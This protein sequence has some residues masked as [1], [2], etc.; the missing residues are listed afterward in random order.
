M[1]MVSS[2]VF[3]L[4]EVVYRGPHVARLYWVM[5]LFTF[6]SVLVARISI[7]EGKERAYLFGLAL[8][9]ATLM[10]SLRLVEFSELS[11]FRPFVL[12]AL[13]AV[14]LWTS[15]KLTWDC[16]VVDSSRDVSSSGLLERLKR[17]WQGAAEDVNQTQTWF[18]RIS[19]L[20][21]SGTR[22]N[23]PGT[24][25]IY[26]GLVA[27]P[28][29]GFG[30]WFV[31]TE[32][33]TWVYLLFA[34]YFAAA[35][36][37]LLTTSLLGLERYL[38]RRGVSVPVPIARNWIVVGGTFALAVMLL[39]S[40]L[41]KPA[42]SS[43][44]QNALAALTSPVR[45]TSKL[46]AGNDGQEAKPDAGNKKVAPD[47][48]E[49]DENGKDGNEPGQQEGDGGKGDGEEDGESDETENEE[50]P[51][52]REQGKKQDSKK[53][54]DAN[55]QQE[56]RDNQRQKQQD[57][58]PKKNKPAEEAEKADKSD[59][60]KQQAPKKRDAKP[61]PEKKQQQ[62]RPQQRQLESRQSSLQQFLASISKFINWLVYL[63]GILAACVLL[64]LFR[65]ELA[66]LWNLLFGKRQK[67]D[68]EI[69]LQEPGKISAPAT[70]FSRFKSPFGAGTQGKSLN[71][72]VNYSMLALEAW[73]REF[74][75]DRREDETPREFAR[76]LETVDP[77]IVRLA[78]SLGELYNLCAFGGKSSVKADTEAIKKLWDRMI[79]LYR[80][81]QV[82]SPTQ[83]SAS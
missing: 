47:G 22:S 80:N 38:V 72:L 83:Q 29:F 75:I 5:G 68:N 30:Q 79:L 73:G 61:E 81:K 77:K 65:S 58:P 53:Q 69:D 48:Q 14:V 55:E 43:S 56:R 8:A 19:S 27:F 76:R 63:I 50:D 6:A 16:T 54:S 15:N 36:G 46:A 52:S 57:V 70:P 34:T 9:I 37:L 11:F 10:A 33:V 51:D 39:V 3:F 44:I 82:Q 49:L 60:T 78:F 66:K 17:D 32:S 23:A 7:E 28:I 18:A 4:I 59:Q 62:Q 25:V 24:W 74:G 13:I 35:L 31:R 26:F 20:F 67:E 2:L 12:M 42:G 1:L 40:L 41:P 71:Q 64:F 45:K 21:V